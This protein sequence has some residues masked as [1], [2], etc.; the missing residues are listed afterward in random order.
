V[1]PLLFSSNQHGDGLKERA[2]CMGAG[3]KT[4][5]TQARQC[6]NSP[7]VVVGAFYFAR[8]SNAWDFRIFV[9]KIDA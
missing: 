6:S 3:A 1:R 8:K 7:L 4:P 2:A 9:N 5:N